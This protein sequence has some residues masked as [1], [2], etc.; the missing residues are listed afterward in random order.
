MI[1]CAAILPGKHAELEHRMGKD[2]VRIDMPKLFAQ[3]LDPSG[4]ATER[5]VREALAVL[6]F[7]SEEISSGKAAELLEI[8]K[9]EFRAL[10]PRFRVP[11]IDLSREELLEDLESSKVAEAARGR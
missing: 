1:Q 7:H 3:I 2:T 5:R 8:S 11:Y 6:L 4:C 10:L 9:A